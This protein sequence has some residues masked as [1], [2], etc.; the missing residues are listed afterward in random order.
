VDDLAGRGVN[1]LRL[2]DGKTVVWGSRTAAPQDPE[3]RYVPVRRTVLLIEKSLERG[4]QWVVFEPNAEALWARV[5]GCVEDF[6]F[7]LWRQ[8]ALQGRKPDEGYFVRCDRS[9]MTQDDLDN[10]R[11]V[12][13]VG[14]AL[15][16]PAEFVVFRTEQRTSGGAQTS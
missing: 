7:L 1:P 13:E 5:R 10:G 16:K 4:L 6:L 8:G 2:L 11:L 15:L 14:V 12:C 3:W 9:T